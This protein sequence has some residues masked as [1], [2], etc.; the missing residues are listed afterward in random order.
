MVI[1]SH[2]KEFLV[3]F[4]N[5]VRSIRK[6]LSLSQEKL[7]FLTGLDRTYIGG[8][9]R[10]ERNLTLLKILKLSQVLDIKISDLFEGCNGD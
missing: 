2:E 8:I 5:R 1:E 3:K 6:K 9:E 7:G 10:G 4:G